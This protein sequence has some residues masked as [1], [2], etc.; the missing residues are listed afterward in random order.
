MFHNYIVFNREPAGAVFHKDSCHRSCSSRNSVILWSFAFAALSLF[1]SCLGLPNSLFELTTCSNDISLKWIPDMRLE[2]DKSGVVPH[3]GPHDIYIKYIETK[4]IVKK[5]VKF[6]YV[7]VAR[8]SVQRQQRATRCIFWYSQNWGFYAFPDFITLKMF[9]IHLRT[10][11]LVVVDISCFID[12]YTNKT[13]TMTKNK[14]NKTI[15][16]S[17]YFT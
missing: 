12:N 5:I 7:G 10:V 1:L 2:R 8:R 11:K 17:Q 14:E 6:D 16:T 4:I 9:V 3:W 15:I 13:R